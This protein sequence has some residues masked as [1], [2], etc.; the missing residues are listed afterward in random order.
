MLGPDIPYVKGLMLQLPKE[1]QV[2]AVSSFP[3]VGTTDLMASS[4]VEN[5][6]GLHPLSLRSLYVVV[7]G[8]AWRKFLGQRN[9]L[10][11]SAV[12]QQ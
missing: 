11:S 5:V 1:T 2:V 6:L 4:L 9:W 12:C 8:E 3:I 10:T 7:G